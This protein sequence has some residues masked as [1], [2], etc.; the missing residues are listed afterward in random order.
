MK[1]VN[2]S[3]TYC[4]KQEHHNNVTWADARDNC[5]IKGKSDLIVIHDDSLMN[6]ITNANIIPVPTWLGLINNN[7]KGNIC[8]YGNLLPTI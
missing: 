7:P 4:Y 5:R 1:D 8:I 2:S 3:W 6:A